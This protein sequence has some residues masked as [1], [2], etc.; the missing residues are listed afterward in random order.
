[1]TQLKEKTSLGHGYKTKSTGQHSTLICGKNSPDGIN[2]HF[3]DSASSDCFLQPC[4]VGNNSPT[5]VK[6]L[7]EPLAQR[8]EELW[9]WRQCL[10]R[11]TSPSSLHL[12]SP[13]VTPVRQWE[14]HLDDQTGGQWFHSSV[15]LYQEQPWS[16]PRK[17][18]FCYVPNF[19]KVTGWPVVS[20][21]PR[22]LSGPMEGPDWEDML[23]P[24]GWT[25]FTVSMF[26]EAGGSNWLT[27][28]Q[29]RTG[30]ANSGEQ[31]RVRAT[32]LTGK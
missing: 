22:P 13:E 4:P 20:M 19:M 27:R 15:S 6:L 29:G 17:Y 30:M 21:Y 26:S 7:Q 31:L 5:T 32:G 24:G 11:K 18:G 28:I 3:P 1:M 10:T 2:G 8:P 12:C 25:P 14:P 23:S 9:S 16:Y